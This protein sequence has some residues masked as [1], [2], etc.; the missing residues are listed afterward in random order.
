MK[1]K[2]QQSM[3]KY[4]QSSYLTYL[5]CLLTAFFASTA[6]SKDGEGLTFKRHR[7]QQRRKILISSVVFALFGGSIWYLRKQWL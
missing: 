7:S 1:R 6:A 2:T 4:M 3:M 5:V